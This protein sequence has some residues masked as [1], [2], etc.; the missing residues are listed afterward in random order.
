MIDKINYKSLALLTAVLLT[1]SIANATNGYFSHGYGIKAKGK[2]GAGVAYSEDAIAAATNPAGMALLGNRVDFGVE[3]FKPNRTAVTRNDNV[4][5]EGNGD[6]AFF[7]PEFGYNRMISDSMSFGV[8]VYGNGGMNTKY[9]SI[10]QYSGSPTGPNTGVNLAQ[11]FVA[12]TLGFKLNEQHA[13]GVSLNLI[14]QTFEASGLGGF[15]GFKAGGCTGNV[16]TDRAGLTDQ[17]ADTSTGYSIKLGWVGQINKQLSVG[18][19]YQ[20]KSEM[21]EF[22]KYNQLFAE[23]GDFDIPSYFIL[24]VNF[25]PNDKWNISFDIQQIN[26]SDVASIAN[27]NDA[28]NLGGS[29]AGQGFLGSSNG[30]GF[31]WDDMTIYKLGVDYQATP[32]LVLRFGYSTGDQPIGANDT[33]FNLIAPAVIEEHATIGGTWTLANKSE[34]SFFYMHAFENTVTGNT[35]GPGSNGNANLTMD[36]DALGIAYG[37]KF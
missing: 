28:A 34:L 30:L 10:P 13:F 8:S 25:K 18:L 3:Y 27:P 22:D 36:Q 6:S 19:S 7:I 21:S 14:Y 17:G 24:G 4:S 33:A 15:C 16:T 2:V 32:N 29:G 31:G 35:I 9:Q 5:Y 11:L 23:Q 1:P 37:W 12:P 26:Y 20:T